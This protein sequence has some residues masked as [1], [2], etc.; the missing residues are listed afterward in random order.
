MDLG[1]DSY[2]VKDL[3]MRPPPALFEAILRLSARPQMDVRDAWAHK[4]TK[5][6]T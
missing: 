5:V 4:A 2:V 6:R 3:L 1:A